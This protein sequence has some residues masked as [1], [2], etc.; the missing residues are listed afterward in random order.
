MTSIRSLAARA[1]V[2]AALATAPVLLTAA[3]AHAAAPGTWAAIAVSVQTGNVG[4]SYDHPSAA[5]ASNAAVDTCDARDC[6][7][8][9]RVSNGCAAVAQASNRAW[10]WSYA[11][12][13]AAAEQGALRA[14]A[15]DGARVLGWVCTGAYR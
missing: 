10:G 1:A 12:S 3:P 7:E 14:T 11:A 2:A 8:V 6:Q 4:Y 15:G 13:R 5:S 9:V